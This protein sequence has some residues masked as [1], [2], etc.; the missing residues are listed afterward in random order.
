MERRFYG[1]RVA[2]TGARVA[3][4]DGV[5]HIVAETGAVVVCGM[6]VAPEPWRKERGMVNGPFLLRDTVV[7][8]VPCLAWALLR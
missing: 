2:I 1:R 4:H 3:N 8:C 5:V 7:T 6:R